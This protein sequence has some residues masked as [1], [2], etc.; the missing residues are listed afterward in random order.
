MSGRDGR[1]GAC[2]GSVPDITGTQVGSAIGL[3]DGG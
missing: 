2:E 3:R 1:W